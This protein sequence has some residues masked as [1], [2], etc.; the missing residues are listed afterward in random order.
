MAIAE[1]APVS[2]THHYVVNIEWTGNTGSGTSGYGSYRRDHDVRAEGKPVLEGSA[3]P[4]FR[5]DAARWNPEELVVAALSQCHMLTY[6][7]LCALEGVVVISYEDRAEGVMEVV[8]RGGGH[9]VE[10][11]LR[12]VVTV[13]DAAMV[14][15]AT[16]LH[17]RARDDC[18]VAASVNF[19]VLHH[20]KVEV[21]ATG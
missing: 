13:S 19:P 8:P 2:N 4:A 11:R 9:F 6:L 18:Y 3:D 15:R 5:G 14:G 16:A 1:R 21:H 20:P 7:A 10:V 17:E 12:P